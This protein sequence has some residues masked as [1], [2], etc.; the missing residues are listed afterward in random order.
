MNQSVRSLLR[1]AVL[2]PVAIAVTV[3]AAPAG[4]A[5]QGP[6]DEPV[7][8]TFNPSDPSSLFSAEQGADWST[9]TVRDMLSAARNGAASLQGGV[10]LRQS[11]AAQTRREANPQRPRP[12]VQ[13]QSVTLNCQSGNGAAEPADVELDGAR[14]V[15]GCV[16]DRNTNVSTSSD[17]A[18]PANARLA[19]PA[20]RTV[21][22]S[23]RAMADVEPAST[24]TKEAEPATGS[25]KEVE[26]ATGSKEAEPTSGAMTD[27]E[28]ASETTATLPTP[29]AQT[30]D[31]TPVQPADTGT[32]TN[33]LISSLLARVLFEQPTGQNT[34]LPQSGQRSPAQQQA[35]EVTGANGSS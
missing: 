14:L 3:A 2:A 35:Q 17:P 13:H 27:A 21:G 32:S 30:D 19:R 4:Y 6:G 29:R 10:N 12:N 24:S 28:P 8:L 31:G 11:R 15:D 25:T 18:V 26:P 33:G 1:G 22:K 23:V 34:L 16:A 9:A 20:A 7:R 5:V